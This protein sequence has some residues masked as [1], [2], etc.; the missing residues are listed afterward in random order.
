MKTHYN[1]VSVLGVARKTDSRPTA[2]FGM[3]LLERSP[4]CVKRGDKNNLRVNRLEI[5]QTNGSGVASHQALTNI[6]GYLLRLA[7]RQLAV[8]LLLVK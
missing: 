1:A 3:P 6:D 5:G 7:L 2:G 4:R 8:H